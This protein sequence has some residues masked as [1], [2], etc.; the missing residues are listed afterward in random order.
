MDNQH[1]VVGEELRLSCEDKQTELVLRIHANAAD[2][3]Y[4][5]DCVKIEDPTPAKFPILPGV[6]HPG[7]NLQAA[8]KFP[9]VGMGGQ[10]QFTTGP[11]A[12]VV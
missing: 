5:K 4:N 6:I 11:R 12:D 7:P 8:V 1:A 10:P 3:K 9:P 2:K